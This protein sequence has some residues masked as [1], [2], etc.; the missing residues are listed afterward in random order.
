MKQI[1]L[2]KN[3]KAILGLDIVKGV[4][5]SFLVIA[6]VSVAVMLALNSLRDSNIF[7]TGSYEYNA[8]NDITYN[9]TDGVRGF[10]GNTGTIF[11]MLVVVVIILSISVIIAVVS[12]FGGPSTS[13]V[14]GL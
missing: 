7:T 13:G 4:I 14:G 10:F 12:R 6:V 9:I 2:N 3:K 8:T 11:A 1:L 5:V